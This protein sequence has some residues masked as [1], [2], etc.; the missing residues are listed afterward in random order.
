MIRNYTEDDVYVQ[1]KN[2]TKKFGNFTAVDN[3]SFSIHKGEILGFLGPNGAGKSTTM[4][5]MANLLRPTSGE[6]WIR[7]NGHLE[8]LTTKTKDHLLDNIGFLIENPAFYGS[9]TPRQILTYFG[10]LKGYPSTHINK[11]VEKVV[12]MFEMS[13]WIDVKTR[14]FSK[15]M[16]QKIGI[17]SA[18]IHDPEIIVLDE[19]HTGLD[20]IARREVRDF[21][22]SLKKQNKTIFLSSH[23]LYEISEV[24][25]RV[26]IISEGKIVALDTLENLEQS[27]KNSIIQLEIAPS[28]PQSS[29]KWIEEFNVIIDPLT[30]LINAKDYITFRPESEIYEIRFNGNPSN[31]KA[32]LKAFIQAGIEVT[33]FSVPKA[34][35]LEDLYVQFVDSSFTQSKELPPLEVSN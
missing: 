35:S 9:M 23:L 1:F 34:D 26:A 30:G 22:L 10:E 25:D 21:I 17:L 5:M 11:R 14:K 3:V 7:G 8:R 6:V 15:G 27:N 4:K 12:A 29:E 13:D 32:I 19:P 33:D 2:V 20:P 16:R 24:A 31:Q 28:K 18:I